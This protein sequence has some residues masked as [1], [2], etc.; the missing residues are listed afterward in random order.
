[1]KID[2]VTE[3]DVVALEAED[4]LTCLLTLSAPLTDDADSRPGEAL[5][6]VLDNSGS[7]AG[8]EIDAAK[9]ALHALVDRMKPQDTF[10]VVT[11]SSTAEIAVPCRKVAD[12]SRDRPCADLGD[13]R[14]IDDRSWGRVCAGAL[15]GRA[16]SVG[17]RGEPAAALRR[18][19]E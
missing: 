15:A 16:R 14:S 12:H 19:C 18:A 6:A 4:D 11:F 7:M 10:G 8:K 9:Q 17:D 1:M 13:L 2:A 5:I 3:F